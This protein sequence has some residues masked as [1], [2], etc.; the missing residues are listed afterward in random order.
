MPDRPDHICCPVCHGTVFQPVVFERLQARIETNLFSCANCTCVCLDPV[1]F[2]RAFEDRP[3]SR[4]SPSG[5]LAIQA[6]G[7]INQRQRERG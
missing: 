5:S 3:S 1:A 4:R 6:W 2:T 7:K